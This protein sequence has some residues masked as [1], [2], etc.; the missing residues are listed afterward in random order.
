MGGLG[1]INHPFFSFCRQINVK[2]TIFDTI[3]EY[4]PKQKA[5]TLCQIPIL[6]M[7]LNGVSKVVSVWLIPLEFTYFQ[8]QWKD[9]KRDWI[10]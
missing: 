6:L 5:H 1:R 9:R 8:N 4:N 3:K 2:Y 7:L 10:K